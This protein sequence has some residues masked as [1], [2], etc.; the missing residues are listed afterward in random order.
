MLNVEKA[1]EDKVYSN[2]KLSPVITAL[3]V[4]IGENIDLS[5]LR[6]HKVIIMAERRCGRAAYKDTA[7]DILLRTRPLVERGHIYIAQ[8]PLYRV[9]KGREEH[10]VYN[11][12]NYEAAAEKNW[13]E[14]N[15]PYRGLR[16]LGEMNPEQLWETTM[17]PETRTIIRS[18]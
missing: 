9:K 16:A 17:N 8:P 18:R 10:Y 13:K 6:Y 4:N 1:R 2:E 15:L 14:G 7:S 11:D 5:R 12:G 3:G